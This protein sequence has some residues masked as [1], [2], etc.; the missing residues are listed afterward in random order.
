MLIINDDEHYHTMYKVTEYCFCPENFINLMY[1][2]L[3]SCTVEL[4][5]F[6]EKIQLASPRKK[7]LRGLL[8]AHQKV[9]QH[10]KPQ[11][12]NLFGFLSKSEIEKREG[13]LP[14]HLPMSEFGKD[15]KV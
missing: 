10:G 14:S 5:N 3:N 8:E 13:N 15:Q 11:Y 7:N 12:L 2:K 1:V 9:I 4:K 6:L